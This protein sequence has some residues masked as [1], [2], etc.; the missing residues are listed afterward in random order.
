M[1]AP[2]VDL[3]APYHLIATDRPQL[4][5][6]HAKMI[7]W[8]KARIDRVD[9]DLDVERTNLDLAVQNGWVHSAFDRRINVLKR[10]RV[11]YEKIVAALDAG[12]AIVPNFQMDVFAIRTALKTPSAKGQVR[13]YGGPDFEQKA[14]ILPA[15]E[16]EYRNPVPSHYSHPVQ[17]PDGKGGVVNKTQF[18]VADFEDVDFPIALAQPALMSRVGEAMALKL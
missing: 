17:E 1:T 4:E 2:S 16:G 13:S 11:F 12:F 3:V 6:A 7:A 9:V 10:Q 8:A 15:G 5:Q 18:N 14:Q